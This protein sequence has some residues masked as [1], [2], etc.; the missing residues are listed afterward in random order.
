VERFVEPAVVLSTVDYGEA[1]RLVVLLT[2]GRG[3]LTAFAAGAR[4][5]KRRFAGALE[6]MTLLDA[7]L[8]ERRGTTYRLDGAAVQRAFQ[9][10][11]GE[12][13]RI[14]RA[15]HAVELCRELCRDHEPHQALFDRL[16]AYLEALDGGQAGPTSLI[17]F[18]LDALAQGGFQPRFDRCALCGGPLEG[19]TRFDP[20]HGGAVCERCAGRSRF[21]VLV[22]GG[23]IAALRALQEG[24]R[25]PLPAKERKVARELLNLF[26]AHQLGRPLRSAEFMVQV[27]VD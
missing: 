21:G 2:R 12:L 8:T 3:K 7:Q 1:D 25:T 14:A 6:S 5:S 16:V 4:K 26:V 18:E 11:R 19:R 15:L 27:G 22:E 20:E 24:S 17:A 13:G 9:G 10:I 23:T